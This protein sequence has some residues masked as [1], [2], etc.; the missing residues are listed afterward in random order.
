MIQLHPS[1]CN[2]YLF[3]VIVSDICYISTWM[4]DVIALKMYIELKCVCVVSKECSR[5]RF[6]VNESKYQ[7]L[8]SL[9]SPIVIYFAELIALRSQILLRSVLYYVDASLLCI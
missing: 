6:H 1:Y 3:F 9:I 2:Y 5:K 8:G 4:Q 7:N